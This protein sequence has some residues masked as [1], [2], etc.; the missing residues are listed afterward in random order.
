M[1]FKDSIELLIGLAAIA[2]FIYKA[3]LLESKVYQ[4]ID[5][6]ED[7]INEKINQLNKKFEVHVTS[8][9]AKKEMQDYLISA[10][11]EKY[12]HKFNRC[13]SEIKIL[14]NDNK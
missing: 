5:S 10:F 3:S 12:D 4:T 8:Y 1:N 2:G 11:N 6:S 7:K 13:W 14:K 9:S